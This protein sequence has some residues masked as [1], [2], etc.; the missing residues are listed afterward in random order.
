MLSKQQGLGWLAALLAGGAAAHAGRRVWSQATAW[1]PGMVSD[2]LPLYLS[3]K[4]VNQGL[5]P[6][7]PGVLQQIYSQLD[8][9]VSMALFSTLYPAST[10][11]LLSPISNQ[12]WSGFLHSWRLIILVVL[13]LGTAAAG[14]GTA[15]GW[16]AGLG[17]AVGAWVAL[18]AYPNTGDALGLGQA[19]LLIVGLLCLAVAGLARDRG[20][21]TGVMAMAGAAVELHGLKG[22]AIP[23]FNSPMPD[24]DFD[25]GPLPDTGPRGYELERARKGRLGIALDGAGETTT[26]ERA[27]RE[28]RKQA[29]LAEW[30]EREGLGHLLS[31]EREAAPA[32]APIVEDAPPPPFSPRIDADAWLAAGLAPLSM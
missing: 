31:P 30:A 24:I 17:A 2:A 22:D 5:D 28:A 6:T 1:E 18:G 14:A 10:A 23:E 8:L 15:R 4:A 25:L 13:V 20:G 19:N 21:L 11:V 29:E 16:R 27:R 9:H 3:A 26:A 7:D 12:G 32:P